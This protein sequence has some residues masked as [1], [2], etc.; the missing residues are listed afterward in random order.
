MERNITIGLSINNFR[1]KII[2]YDHM[3]K[4]D[5]RNNYGIKLGTVNFYN[6]SININQLYEILIELI[7]AP[8]ETFY[9]N[10]GVS[11]D[12]IQNFFY[13]YGHMITENKIFESL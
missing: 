12:I 1:T 9:T 2:V 13:D 8:N 10:Y 5:Y 4:K 7:R 3:S 11:Y 6:G